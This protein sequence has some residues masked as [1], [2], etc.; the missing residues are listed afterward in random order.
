VPDAGRDFAGEYALLGG[1]NSRTK[2]S[3][4]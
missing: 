2:R 1:G 3:V 4:R